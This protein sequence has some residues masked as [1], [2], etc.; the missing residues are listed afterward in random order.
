MTVVYIPALMLRTH[1]DHVTNDE[2]LRQANMQRLR[3][4]AWR[5][6]RPTGF[7]R[8]SY[9]QKA[10]FNFPYNEKDRI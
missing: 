10:H 1:S 8:V 2:V 3:D 7:T 4:V 9:N 5:R 6:V